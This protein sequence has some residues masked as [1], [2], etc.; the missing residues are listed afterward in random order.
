MSKSKKE[1]DVEVLKEIFKMANQALPDDI[2]D[3]SLNDALTKIKM[4]QSDI[5]FSDNMDFNSTSNNILVIDDIG[6][7]TYQLKVMLNNLGYSVQ[8]AKDIF[9]GL[10]TFIK[11]NYAFVVMDLF[12]STEQEGLTLLY[13]TKK[14]ITQNNLDTKIIVMTASNRTEDKVKCLNGGA[15]IFLKKEAGWQDKLVETIENFSKKDEIE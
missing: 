6:V 7:V 2:T 13:E 9:S 12:V 8:I 3:E 14:I 10:N 5:A 15:D 11:S 1:V 4:S